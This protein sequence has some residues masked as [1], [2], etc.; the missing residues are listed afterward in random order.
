MHRNV[1]YWSF[2]ENTLEE[3]RIGFVWRKREMKLH[4]VFAKDTTR[5]GREP[6][7]RT[8]ITMVI[9]IIRVQTGKLFF[10]GFF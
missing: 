6:V 5:N 1:F 2:K 9:S 4:K 7:P 10:D 8:S 3:L